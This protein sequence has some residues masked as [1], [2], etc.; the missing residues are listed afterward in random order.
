MLRVRQRAVLTSCGRAAGSCRRRTDRRL[1]GRSSQIR[2]VVDDRDPASAVVPVGTPPVVRDRP[3]RH[4]Q[5]HRAGADQVVELVL[6]E[7]LRAGTLTA[8]VRLRPQVAR[9]GGGTADLERDQVVL[10][11]VLRQAVAAEGVAGAQLIDLESC[12]VTGRWPH[13]RRVAGPADRR[14]DRL[15][16]NCRIGRAG[17]PT[18]VRQHDVPTGE[19]YDAPRGGSTVMMRSSGGRRGLTWNGYGDRGGTGYVSSRHRR[20]AI[21]RL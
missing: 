8:D 2:A 3:L 10:F 21:S 16:S 1:G 17:R 6:H 7:V 18:P 19:Q 5:R 4:P 12:R 14:A 13:R 20:A 9:T 15:L 11:V